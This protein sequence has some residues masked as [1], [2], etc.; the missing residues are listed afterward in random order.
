MSL[1]PFSFWNGQPVTGPV[2]PQMGDALQTNAMGYNGAGAGAGY[3]MGVGGAGAA[4]AAAAAATAGSQWSRPG[5]QTYPSAQCLGMQQRIPQQA[6]PPHMTRSMSSMGDYGGAPMTC[7]MP[8]NFFGGQQQI[9]YEPCI[10]N[11][12]AFCAYNGMDMNINCHAGSGSGSGGAQSG[13][14][15][16]FW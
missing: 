9:Q 11:G 8:G 10:E 3:G 15:G 14:K 5:L 12:E 13:E 6:P 4:A 1:N 16:D 7:P 2:Y